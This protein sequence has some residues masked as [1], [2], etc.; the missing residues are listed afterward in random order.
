LVPNLA[1]RTKFVSTRFSKSLAGAGAENLKSLQLKTRD[2]VQTLITSNREWKLNSRACQICG[3][4]NF[5]KIAEVDRYL[6]DV[7]TVLCNSCGFMFT[8]PVMRQS[9][10][11]DFYINYYREL[12]TNSSEATSEFFQD[13]YKTGTRIYKYLEKNFSLVDKTIVEIGAGAGGILK[14]FADR[15]LKVI[16]CDF[17]K[18]YLNYGIKQGVNLQIGGI[19]SIPSQSAD[20]VI[21]CHV[22]EHILD[23]DNEFKNLERILKPGGLIYIEVPGIFYVHYTY[24]GNF[25]KFLQNAHLYH[26]SKKTLTNLMSKHKF[27][28]LKVNQVINGLFIHD[29]S[30][31]QNINKSNNSITMFYLKSI[32]LLRP[33]LGLP[34]KGYDLI[35]KILK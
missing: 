7:T 20:V 3:Q 10:Y 32:E 19:E 29:H 18:D 14:A 17:G 16:G 25:L 9:D 33:I 4:E 12:Y 21:Y 23:L 1:Y 13:Q 22:L 27:K 15:G 26:F 35:M 24:R 28:P 5:T 6:L 31:F 34:W 30:Q 11:E 8:D 2:V